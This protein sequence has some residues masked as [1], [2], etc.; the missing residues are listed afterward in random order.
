MRFL[1]VMVVALGLA[2]CNYH[3]KKNQQPATEP[4]GPPPGETAPTYALVREQILEP[5]CLECHNTEIA[6]AGLDL[7]TH[8]GA[9]AA[10]TRNDPSESLLYNM[11]EWEEMPPKRRI[12]PLRFL[13]PEEKETVKAWIEAGA[14][15]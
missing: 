3:E 9:L 5:L 15:K 10:V 7:S 6:K 2:G 1:G 13:T 12:P 11:V 14:P 8:E 4:K